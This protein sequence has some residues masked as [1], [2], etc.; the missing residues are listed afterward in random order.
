MKIDPYGFDEPRQT[1]R[2]TL[3]ARAF[4][5]PVAHPRFPEEE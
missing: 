5:R 2:R 3:A 1:F 4:T